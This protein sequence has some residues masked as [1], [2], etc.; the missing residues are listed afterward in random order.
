[1]ELDT[2]KQIL[3]A[4]NIKNVKDAEAISPDSTPKTGTV[5]REHIFL[6]SIHFC[7]EYVQT[8]MFFSLFFV[9]SKQILAALN[10]K[11]VKDAEAEYNKYVKG[12]MLMNVDGT[13]TYP[14]I[15]PQR[16]AP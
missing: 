4:L 16:P 8:L 6:F 3:A 10:I 1:V 11:N 7:Y 9:A 15:A 2:K 13:A 12:D 5:N 14:Q